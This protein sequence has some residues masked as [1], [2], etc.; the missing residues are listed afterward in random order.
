MEAASL[1]AIL[2]GQAHGA[3]HHGALCAPA[4]ALNQAHSNG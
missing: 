1:L 2:A 4:A 3:P